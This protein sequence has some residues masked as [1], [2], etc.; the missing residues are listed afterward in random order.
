[1]LCFK[2][3]SQGSY[4]GITARVVNDKTV[5]TVVAARIGSKSD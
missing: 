3:L 5:T 2:A 4:T 1:L